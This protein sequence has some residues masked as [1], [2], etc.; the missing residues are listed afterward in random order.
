MT[1]KRLALCAAAA[2]LL[3]SPAFAATELVANG[4]FETG[5]FT[6]WNTGYTAGQNICCMGFQSTGGS[7][8]STSGANLGS[9]I[10]GSFSAYGD[11]DGGDGVPPIDLNKPTDFFVR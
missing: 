9:A 2:T 3:A 4:G 1:M 10:G 8:V 11:W 6:G 5:D 7:K